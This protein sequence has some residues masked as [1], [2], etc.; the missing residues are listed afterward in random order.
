[1]FSFLAKTKR[2][3]G[4][5]SFSISNA[6]PHPLYDLKE[7]IAVV[8]AYPK[9]IE[10]GIFPVVA[11]TSDMTTVDEVFSDARLA[12]SFKRWTVD[13]QAVVFLFI[14][15]LPCNIKA[16]GEKYFAIA[17]WMHS[18]SAY[19]LNTNTFHIE[20]SQEGKVGTYNLYDVTPSRYKL[21]NSTPQKPDCKTVKWEGFKNCTSI[22]ELIA[23]LRAESIQQGLVGEKGVFTSCFKTDD[24]IDIC[25]HLEALLEIEKHNA[26][27]EGLAS[28]I[29]SMGETLKSVGFFDHSPDDWRR[30]DKVLHRVHDYLGEIIKEDL[31]EDTPTASDLADDVFEV[32]SKDYIGL[33]SSTAL[34]KARRKNS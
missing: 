14:N 21:T 34:I 23:T 32:M 3:Q 29:K 10:K 20:K 25:T 5:V 8:A 6:M 16:F 2:R 15:E 24:V 12:T 7:G 22:R 30:V 11:L 1:M 13:S 26:Y 18:Y 27:E 28:G 4:I 9:Y 19:Y 31:V 17:S 33:Y